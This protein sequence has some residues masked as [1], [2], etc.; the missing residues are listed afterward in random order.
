MRKW[1]ITSDARSPS[2]DALTEYFQVYATPL[3]SDHRRAIRAL[4]KPAAD[5]APPLI[6]EEA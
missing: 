1:G 2:A 6:E 4:F 5:T 3:S